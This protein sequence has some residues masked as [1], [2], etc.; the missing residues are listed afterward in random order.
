M[1]WKC[2][3]VLVLTI[4]R[5]YT[6]CITNPKSILIYVPVDMRSLDIFAV[7]Y[8]VIKYPSCLITSKYSKPW[9]Y[10]YVNNSES[11]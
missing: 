11:S 2:S 6:Q 1:A 5:V 4:P 8:Y 9:S 3:L 10:L 7:K